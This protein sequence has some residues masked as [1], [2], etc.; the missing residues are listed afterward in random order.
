MCHNYYS[1]GSSGKMAIQN[2]TK[3]KLLHRL[4]EDLFFKAVD[5][6]IDHL[7]IGWKWARLIDMEPVI[8]LFVNQSPLTS[9]FA[10]VKTTDN[11]SSQVIHQLT[12]VMGWIMTRIIPKFGLSIQ[13]EVGLLCRGAISIVQHLESGIT[14]GAD[15]GRRLFLPRRSPDGRSPEATDATPAA[16]PL[17]ARRRG[18]ISKQFWKGF[19][20]VTFRVEATFRWWMRCFDC[21][22]LLR[23]TRGA[24]RGDWYGEMEMISGCPA[25]G[26]PPVMKLMGDLKIK[27]AASIGI[28]QNEVPWFHLAVCCAC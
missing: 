25:S 11:Q 17:L 10:L 21:G 23:Q 24:P 8:H 15:E 7:G 2:N 22:A 19:V 16:A 13:S 4:L 27:L 9:R 20:R 28:D 26:L 12:Q 6:V 3:K 18:S 14:D 1:S 5:R